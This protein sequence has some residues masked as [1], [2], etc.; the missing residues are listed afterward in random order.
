M[1]SA[2]RKAINTR[3]CIPLPASSVLIPPIQSEI[4]PETSLEMTPH[5]SIMDNISAPRWVANPR[6]DEYATMCTWGIDMPTQQPTPAKHS[7][8]CNEL[9]A[10]PSGLLNGLV[11]FLLSSKSRYGGLR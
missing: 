7:N 4:H 8:P 9:G 11:S 1:L 5:P 2:N 3:I 6:S 10:S